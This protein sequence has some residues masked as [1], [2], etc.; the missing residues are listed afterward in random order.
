LTLIF[1]TFA[2]TDSGRAALEVVLS[3]GKPCT[4][5][6]ANDDLSK[7]EGAKVDEA[8]VADTTEVAAIAGDRSTGGAI[9]KNE[10]EK[11]ASLQLWGVLSC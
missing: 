8:M 9:L 2:V 11:L 4:A 3:A 7:T 10:C 6:P 1:L 5:A